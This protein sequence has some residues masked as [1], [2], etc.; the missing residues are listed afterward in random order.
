M[1]LHT[2]SSKTFVGSETAAQDV[3]GIGVRV[4]LYLQG[5]GMILCMLRS[6]TSGAGVK[7]VSGSITISMLASWTVLAS[8]MEFSPCEA[9]L[10]LFL[11]TAMLA[12]GKMVLFNVDSLVGEGL[13]LCAIFV[14]ELWMCAAHGW[15]FARLCI[16]LPELGTE[17]VAFFF[18]KVSLDGWFR[19]FMLV[20][21][22][23]LDWPTTLLWAVK[24]VQALQVSIAVFQRGSSRMTEDE[25][26]KANIY[27]MVSPLRKL[28]QKQFDT[29]IVSE[30]EV[31]AYWTWLEGYE[32]RVK[33]AI[34]VGVPLVLWIFAVTT[35][36]T[37]IRWNNLTPS[38]DLGSP[39]QLIPFI[40][41]IC[42]FLDGLLVVC[43]PRARAESAAW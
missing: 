36:E 43:R 6:R 2:R 29:A 37:T 14:T 5:A 32:A 3:Y 21:C 23:L 34:K 35:V 16:T 7:L 13:G 41:G 39:G 8:N 4:G 1:P 26:K 17:N 24:V 9:Y 33:F 31:Q 22:V 10:V 25:L 30:T 11:L 28:F 20:L 18:A 42:I 15:L 12:P 19:V 27:D 38:N 40:T